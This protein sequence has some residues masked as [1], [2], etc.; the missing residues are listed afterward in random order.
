MELRC[1]STNIEIG[2]VRSSFNQFDLG[3]VMSKNLVN[4]G[5]YLN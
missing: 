2:D 5:D 4:K 1:E 3:D